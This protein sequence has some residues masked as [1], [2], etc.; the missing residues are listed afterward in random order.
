[1][2]T[3]H[4]LKSAVSVLK[5]EKRLAVSDFK[6]S[7]FQ[8]RSE[9]IFNGLISQ[10]LIFTIHFTR[11]L[12]L[13][14]THEA[15]GPSLRP[16]LA[17]PASLKGRARFSGLRSRLRPS[18]QP[19]QLE[20]SANGRLLVR[21]KENHQQQANG[22]SGGHIVAARAPAVQSGPP[23]PFPWSRGRRAAA[24]DGITADCPAPA[25]ALCSN[26]RTPAPSTPAPKLPARPPPRPAAESSTPPPL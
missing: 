21:K 6:P 12:H 19:P 11:G 14:A 18:P 25:L 4:P 13:P 23:P 22:R 16:Q 15:P 8:K 24:A 20:R 7:D 5:T 17:R 3:L 2:V 9:T 26:L 10:W 1:M